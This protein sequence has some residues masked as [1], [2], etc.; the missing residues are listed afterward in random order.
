MHNFVVRLFKLNL[1]SEEL[2][3]SVALGLDPVD[4]FLLSAFPDLIDVL[5]ELVHESWRHL[6]CAFVSK[7]MSYL[8]SVLWDPVLPFFILFQIFEL[9]FIFRNLASRWLSL[10]VKIPD[11]IST[12]CCELSKL[13]KLLR[14]SQKLHQSLMVL[15][16]VLCLQQCC[17]FTLSVENCSV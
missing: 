9:T 12:V 7:V 1:S 17:A 15:P 13:F 5:E 6:A 16:V 4:L 14:L 11:A 8:K 10:R 3:F 2:E